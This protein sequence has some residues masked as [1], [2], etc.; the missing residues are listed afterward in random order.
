MSRRRGLE[1]VR[2]FAAIC[3]VAAVGG[4]GQILGIDA[5][6]EENDASTP[7]GGE[8]GSGIVPGQDGSGT[9]PV[10][11]GTGTPDTSALDDGSQPSGDTG[12]PDSTGTGSLDASDAGATTDAAVCTPDAALCTGDGGTTPETC[13]ASGQWQ[14]GAPCAYVCSAGTCTGTC[15]P[16]SLQCD[17]Q[18]PQQCSAAG[19]WSNSGSSCPNVCNAG[20]CAGSCSPGAEQCS[21]LQPQECTD[22]GVWQSNGPACAYVCTSGACTGSCVPGAK[23]CLGSTTTPQTCSSTGTWV[24]GSPCPYLCTSGVCT[25]VCTAGSKEC[26]TTSNGYLTCGSNNQWGTTTTLCSSSA[27]V[28][29]ACVGVCSPG[30]TECSTT[31]DG[32]LTCSSAGEWGTTTTAC[33]SS[34]CVDGGCT[35]NCVPGSTECVGTTSVETCSTAGEYGPATLCPPGET[36]SSGVCSC[37]SGDVVCGTSCTSTQTDPLNCGT[38]GHSCLGGTC[39]AGMCQPITIAAL[40][41]G[42]FNFEFGVAID[43]TNIYFTTGSASQVGV[44]P[45]TGCTVI[46]PSGGATIPTYIYTAP[47]GADLAEMF[48][49]VAAGNIYMSDPNNGVIYSITTAGSLNWTITGRST[50]GFLTSDGTNLYWAEEGGL[51]ASPLA[52]PSVSTIYSSPGNQMYGIWY[53]PTSTDLFGALAGNPG[54]VVECTSPGRVFGSCSLG[55]SPL[56]DDPQVLMVQGSTILIGTQGVSNPSGGGVFSAPVSNPSAITALVSG[57]AYGNVLGIT[58]DANN[59]YFAPD[60]P[61][62]YACAIGGC[63][64]TPVTLATGTGEID[65]MVNDSQ[66]LY[67]GSTEKVMKL[68]K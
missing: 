53:D 41:G 38:C 17:G 36:C 20:V 30:T 61:G 48:Y 51:F 43:T 1:R 16:G 40:Y 6:T 52:G 14:T 57:S 33:S 25:G 59:V 32:Y 15:I 54:D 37:P 21:L 49:D 5:V 23:Q 56:I 2:L 10:D 45:L 8:D 67:W 60:G 11:S 55:A 34:A 7:G 63:G 46:N 58:A 68:A 9:V 66:Y 62:I 35:G 44:C 24:S 19:T 18:Q 42:T 39:S 27:C 3:A 12:A 65:T 47:S 22:A 31:S 64:G 4:C 28:G 26:S 13:T 29:G 50:P